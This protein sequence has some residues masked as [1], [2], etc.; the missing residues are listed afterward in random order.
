MRNAIDSVSIVRKAP[1]LTYLAFM[2]LITA[3]PAYAYVGPGGGISAI[4][5]LIALISAV[6]LALVGFLWFPI[7][8]LIKSMKKSQPPSEE[9]GTTTE[10]AE[11]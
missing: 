9:S 7:K 1:L 3:E 10:N 11:E 2:I 5:S 4:G 8:R 6:F